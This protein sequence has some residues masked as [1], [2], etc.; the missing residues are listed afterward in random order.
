MDK[1]NNT[2]K[3][4]YATAALLGLSI[5]SLSACSNKG[6]A[7]RYEYFPVYSD[8]KITIVNK[9]GETAFSGSYDYAVMGLNGEV[10]VSENGK[11]YSLTS[12]SKEEIE[13][14]TRVT[15]VFDGLAFGKDSDGSI[16]P[17][18]SSYKKIGDEVYSSLTAMRDG[19]GFLQK[20]DE[21][22]MYIRTK[23]KVVSFPLDGYKLLTLFTEKDGSLD[24]F[25]LGRY[26]DGLSGYRYGDVKGN[27][28]QE[29][30]ETGLLY[31]D[32]E[33]VWFS[34]S[35][36]TDVLSL[37]DNKLTH[38]A[39][40]LYYLVEESG[41]DDYYVG[42]H[43]KEVAVFNKD[44]STLFSTADSSVL[45][46]FFSMGLCV[47]DGK[48]YYFTGEGT[49]YMGKDGVAHKIGDYYGQ[50]MPS[51][52]KFLVYKTGS[53]YDLAGKLVKTIPL[54]NR[55]GIYYCFSDNTFYIE[56][57]DGVYDASGSCIYKFKG[58]GGIV[59]MVYSNVLVDDDGSFS[60]VSLSSHKARMSVSKN[61]V[62]TYQLSKNGVIYFYNTTTKN[63]FAYTF[64]GD[65]LTSSCDIYTSAHYDNAYNGHSS[66][67]AF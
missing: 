26:K 12:S 9:K 23:D 5:L 55:G 56:G 43:D 62:S 63:G 18:D 50:M 11:A 52:K 15:P 51:E 39:D 67:S 21:D 16:Y 36:S 17:L 60:L 1:R 54:E 44:G 46:G 29:Y 49:F 32:N 6:E 40:S 28:S 22:S 42:R 3:L 45:N 14:Y 7:S 66:L 35:S 53:I 64:D 41:D 48:L 59:R 31:G 61:V 10:A 27:L 57:D 34:S 20:K 58:E 8:S 13:G 4:R 24:Y 19:I 2:K 37:T 47:E 38:L 33:K 25:L 30:S 65:L